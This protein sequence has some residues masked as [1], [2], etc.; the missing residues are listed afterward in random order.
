MKTRVFAMAALTAAVS[1]VSVGFAYDPQFA[2]YYIGRDLRTTIPT[3]TY[4]GLPNPNFNRITFLYAHTY[5]DTPSNNHYHGK[6]NFTYV[7]PNLGAATA[8]QPFNGSAAGVPANFLPEGVFGNSPRL[9]LLPGSGVFAGKWVSGLD[10][11]ENFGRLTIRSV[12]ALVAPASVPNSPAAILFNSS[13]G[14]WNGLIGG[15]NLTLH[16]VDISPGLGVADPSGNVLMTTPGDSVVL[17]NPD[18][19]FSFTPVFFTTS[20]LQANH[21]AVFRI[22]DNGTANGGLPF[23]ESGQFQFNL[24]VPEPAALGLLAPLGVLLTR[25]RTA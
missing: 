25:R 11:D 2:E 1:G 3:G 18:A 19:D 8:V 21:F 7:G 17:G 22:T 12:D 16:L 5:V 4:A 24:V 10:P 6:S 20:G 23:P 9:Q 13:Q 14:R 15:S